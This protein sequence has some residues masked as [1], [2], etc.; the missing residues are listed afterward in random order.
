MTTWFLQRFLHLTCWI[1]RVMWLFPAFSAWL[2]ARLK[3]LWLWKT[4]IQSSWGWRL[5]M[6]ISGALWFWRSLRGW[7]HI[8]TSKIQSG[9]S[10]STIEFCKWMGKPQPS[11]KFIG[12]ECL[13]FSRKDLTLWSFLSHDL[14]CWLWLGF[15][16]G[17]SDRALFSPVFTA[18]CSNSV[19]DVVEWDIMRYQ[20]LTKYIQI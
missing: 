13:P 1:G 12:F 16:L 4:K 2:A 9:P 17:I 11:P 7:S 19:P 14:R 6:Q 8:S 3:S 18:N 10:A 5:T 20:I 15:T